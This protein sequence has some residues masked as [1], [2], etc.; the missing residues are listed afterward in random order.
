MIS[1]NFISLYFV[2]KFQKE[3]SPNIRE[4]PIKET[5]NEEESE[6]E[7][8]VE[9][10]QTEPFQVSE[11]KVHTFKKILSKIFENTKRYIQKYIN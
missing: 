5:S 3:R 10:I 9:F 11:N 6:A 2:G 1:V 7:S 4:Q 8:Q